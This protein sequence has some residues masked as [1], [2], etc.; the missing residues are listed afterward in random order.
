M[1]EARPLHILACGALARE[2]QAS[3]AQPGM[4][5]AELHCLPAKLH[6]QPQKIPAAVEAYLDALPE[7]QRVYLAYGDCGTGGALARLCAARGVEMMDVP[8]CYAL[9]DAAGEFGAGDELGTFYLT[10]FLARQF[11]T[12]IWVGLGLDRHPELRDMY[13]A[14]YTTLVY[15]AQS[16]DP[17]L[18]AKARAAAEKLGLRY[19]Q[20]ATGLGALPGMLRR[21]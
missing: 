11:D 20:R 5:E 17:G 3:L 13:F 2:I 4:P 8:H 15:L 10:D 9:F 6:N 19:E 16:D 21:A 14:H 7:G 12:L 18:E 1:T